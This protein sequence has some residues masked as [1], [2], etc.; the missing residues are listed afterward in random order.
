MMI[1]NNKKTMTKIDKLKKAIQKRKKLDNDIFEA[2]GDLTRGHNSIFVWYI[3]DRITNECIEQRFY[4]S[5][6][7]FM[8]AEA[9]LMDPCN[10]QWY[11]AIT[12]SAYRKEVEC[13]CEGT[14]G[15]ILDDMSPLN[16]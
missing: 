1:Q 13:I 6:A 8:R 5:S 7:A 14:S 4:T 12:R 9:K 16:T 3:V 2:T 10:S 11:R 15:V